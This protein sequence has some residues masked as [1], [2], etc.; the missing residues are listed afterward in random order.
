M[1]TI[2]VKE[3][4]LAVPAWVDSNAANAKTSAGN[5]RGFRKQSMP[6]NITV[7]DGLTSLGSTRCSE[8]PAEDG[9]SKRL[10]CGFVT[11][12]P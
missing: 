8:R 9:G 11:V 4:A 6:S 2:R 5:A 7:A 12:C 10:F 1:Y 3:V